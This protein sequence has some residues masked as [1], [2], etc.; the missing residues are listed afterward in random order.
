MVDSQSSVYIRGFS[1]SSGTHLT[2]ARN[3]SMVKSG[4]S[5]DF[6][7]PSASGADI[8]ETPSQHKVCS[9]QKVLF[10]LSC[11]EKP[12]KKEIL[13]MEQDKRSCLQVSQ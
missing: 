8:K 5:K 3:S 12:E 7:D 13:G 11:N 6:Q 9:S 4:S 1:D 10:F 2:P